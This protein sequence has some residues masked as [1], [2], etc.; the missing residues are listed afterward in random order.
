MLAAIFLGMMAGNAWAEPRSTREF[1][2]ILAV[3]TATSPEGVA[4]SRVSG[5]K[6]RLKKLI[7]E[8]KIKKVV[9]DSNL[10]LLILVESSGENGAV[11]DT[12][13]AD[14][15]HAYG[16]L[17][18]RQ[19]YVTDINKHFGT[20][21]RSTDC[22]YDIE[23]SKLLVQ[24]YMN[25]YGEPQFKFQEYARIHNGGPVG[26]LSTSTDGYWRKIIEAKMSQ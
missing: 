2:P 15:E 8:G 3:A 10:D 17:Q 7:R 21:L 26:H 5:S 22:Q 14:G 4:S 1:R 6:E 23:L 16:I 9:S 13:L 24:A 11:G 12:G 19:C 20:N 25:I 18:I